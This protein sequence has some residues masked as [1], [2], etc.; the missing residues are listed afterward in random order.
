MFLKWQLMEQPAMCMKNHKWPISC[1]KVSKCRSTISD[2]SKCITKIGTY[3]EQECKHVAEERNDRLHV[4]DSH[5]LKCVER[6]CAIPVDTALQLYNTN[7]ATI[8]K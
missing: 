7:S 2:Q 1:Q 6:L 4:G 5:L 8:N 3:R